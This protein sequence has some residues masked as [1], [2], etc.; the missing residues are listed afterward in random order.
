[1]SENPIQFYSSFMDNRFC[2]RPTESTIIVARKTRGPDFTIKRSFY[3]FRANNVQKDLCF[4]ARSSNWENCY[5]S[6]SYAQSSVKELN[7][8]KTSLHLNLNKKNFKD[9][10]VIWKQ[11]GLWTRCCVCLISLIRQGVSLVDSDRQ[12]HRNCG[13]VQPVRLLGNGTH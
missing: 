13:Q 12:P 1:M 5:H 10:F 8:A 9:E 4:A 11:S 7:R 3:T 2:T 6:F